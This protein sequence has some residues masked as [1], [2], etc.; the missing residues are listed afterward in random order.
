MSRNVWKSCHCKR[1]EFGRLG[2]NKVEY[3]LAGALALI[4]VLS[5]LLTF[6]GLIWGGGVNAKLG[7]TTFRGRPGRS[8]PGP[9][10]GAHRPRADGGRGGAPGRRRPS[11]HLPGV[12][13]RVRKDAEGACRDVRG[14]RP[15][16]QGA[17]R[18]DANADGRARSGLP[19]V[20]GKKV[21]LARDAMPQLPEM[22]RVRS[23]EG[24]V[25]GPP[26]AQAAAGQHS[27]RMSSLQD[28]HR[29]VAQTAQPQEEVAARAGRPV[30]AWSGPGKT[31]SAAAIDFT[32]P[33][34]WLRARAVP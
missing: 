26:Y 9:G 17:G 21:V 11:F 19:A 32:R 24:D 1:L 23:P 14:A 20:W 12:P 13:T 18:H 22:V 2:G 10:P 27:A 34:P 16:V 31:M 4:I 6:K 25:R 7:I 30:A 15:D 8:P 5:L 3:I 33:G 29:R 28:R